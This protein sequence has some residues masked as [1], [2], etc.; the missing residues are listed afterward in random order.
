[1]KQKWHASNLQEV[2]T[3]AQSRITGLTATEVADRLRRFGSN[4]LPTE[5][6]PSLLRLIIGQFNNPLLFILF[7]AVVLSLALRHTADAIFIIMVVVINTTLGVYQEYKV[8]K[9]L[10]M[11]RTLVRFSVRVK[12]SGQITEVDS[13]DL[14]PGDIIFLKAGDR[15]PADSY[16]LEVTDLEVNEASLTGESVPVSKATGVLPHDTVLSERKNMVFMGTTVAAGKGIAVVVATGLTTKFG[17][18]VQLLKNTEQK[19]TP[20]QNQIAILARWIGA[21]VIVISLSIIVI[22]V[23]RGQSL[24]EISVASL[25]LAVSAIPEGLL[26]G[27][28]LVLVLGMRRILIQQG[29]VRKLLA[30]ETL[31]GVTVIC[32]DKTGTL[33][34]GRME[35]VR[36][37]SAGEELLGDDLPAVSG[38]SDA[39]GI[40]MTLRIAGLTNDAFVDHDSQGNILVRGALTDQALLM[41]AMKGGF[42][43]QKLLEQYPLLDSLPFNSR[44]K[45]AA[46]L[47]RSGPHTLML[48]VVGAPEVVL[49][50]ATTLQYAGSETHLDSTEFLQLKETVAALSGQGYRVLAC[51]YKYY[52][53]DFR[54]PHLAE[55]VQKLTIA[56]YVVIADPI[57]SDVP[58]AIAAARRAGI[59]TIVITGDN[60]LTAQAICRQ[61]GLDISTHQMLDGMELDAFTDEQFAERLKSVRLFARVSPEHKL[62]I[63]K[64]LEANGHIVA[65]IGDGVNDA[66]A[67]QASHVGVSVGSGTDVAKQT[68]D[69]VLLNDS[70]ATIVKAI[71]QGRIIFDNIR[72]VFIYLMADGF[73]EVALFVGSVILGLPIPL[74]PIQILWINLIEDGFPGLALTTEQETAGVMDQPPRNPKE[75]IISRALIFWLAVVFLVNASAALGVFIYMHTAG[76]SLE[77]TRTV[78]F[79]L[80]IVDSLFFLF[81]IRSLRRSLWRRDV[82]NNKYVTGAAV[83]SVLALCG[84]LYAGPL[85]N[86]LGTVPLSGM[87]WLVIV[88]ISIVEIIAIEIGKFYLLTKHKK[89][90]II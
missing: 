25:A 18:I 65:M 13:A 76:F 27:I 47:H 81:S 33:T 41:G 90:A 67:L 38:R 66:P 44:D 46:T 86:L 59:T 56:G 58:E 82:F 85:Q 26:A 74:L 17:G 54:Y 42:E 55:V 53:Q 31:G 20:L 39:A 75:P 34:E 1:M 73:S 19:L 9:S 80:T 79:A 16:M 22:G 30:T 32:T 89:S 40:H 51:A 78:V 68:A 70:F 6:G 23:L 57:R 60:R 69:I 29:L 45:F 7:V 14:V 77:L 87:H 36:V 10:D 12:R 35:M 64:T 52:P 84:A 63:V 4:T 11:L 15:V 2:L 8:N 3:G 71:E 61:V 43:K 83:F 49:E 24:L 21:I 37:L 88:G 5:H 62:R 48:S 72:K 28:T 50:H